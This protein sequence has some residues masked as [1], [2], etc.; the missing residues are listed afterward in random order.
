MDAKL[1][2]IIK[3]LDA[4]NAELAD[5]KKTKKESDLDQVKD[6]VRDDIIQFMLKHF[7]IKSLND[8]TEEQYYEWVFDG[9]WSLTLGKL[10]PN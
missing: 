9:L 5:L 10:L 6:A 7:N 1:D 2:L 8:K 3:K 4:V